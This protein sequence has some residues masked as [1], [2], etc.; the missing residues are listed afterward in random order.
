M[1]VRLVSDLH[2][3]FSSVEIPLEDV[4]VLVLAG[5]MSPHPEQTADWIDRRVPKTLKTLY[6]PGNHEYEGHYINTHTSEMRKAL[7]PFSNVKLLQNDSHVHEGVRFLGTTLWT[8]FAAFPQFGSA[9]DAMKRAKYVI[10][11]P[12]ES[13]K[14]TAPG[15]SSLRMRKMNFGLRAVFCRACWR[16]RLTGRRWS[17][18]T[19]CHPQ[20]ACSR[21]TPLHPSTPI[22]HVTWRI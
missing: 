20:G 18:A 7:K 6:V 10:S 11:P 19:F 9:E 4:D 21:N 1:K 22:L 12:S 13:R 14:R 5:D 15:H 3:N 16:N 17:S 2:I 8:N